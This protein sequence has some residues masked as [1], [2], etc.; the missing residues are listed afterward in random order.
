MKNQTYLLFNIPVANRKS[1]R[2][3]NNKDMK[4]ITKKSYIIHPDGISVSASFS[5]SKR[6]EGWMVAEVKNQFL[7][8]NYYKKGLKE[9]PQFYYDY[10]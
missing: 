7:Q 5:A 8:C 1:D 10:T 9:G 6:H 2:H 4:I 3:Q